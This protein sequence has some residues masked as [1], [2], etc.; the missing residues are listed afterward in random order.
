MGCGDIGRRVALRLK[1]STQNKPFKTTALVVSDNSVKSCQSLDIPTLQHDLDSTEPLYT[2]EFLNGKV[3]YF[4]PPP[5]DGETDTRLANF[6]S[7]VGDAPKRIVLISTTGV[8]G[9]CNGSWVDENTPLDPQT[10]RAKRRASAE[11]LLQEWAK[12]YDREYII[13]RVPGIYALDRLPLTRLEKKLPIV[14]A[15]EAAFTNRIHADDLAEICI[16]AMQSSLTGEVFNATDGTPGTMVEYFNQVA[17]YANL[18][19]PKQISLKEAE[20]KLSQGM[21]SYALESRRIGNEK[22]L[23]LLN[24]KLKY[25]TLADTL[26]TP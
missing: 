15:S 26:K 1:D 14:R 18:P 13:L 16:Q 6:L 2:A 21:L 20:E 25:P 24:V 23:K 5:K 11:Q 7:E 19:R 22:L 9:N 3:F 12:K 4:A 8:Y 17:D 10:G